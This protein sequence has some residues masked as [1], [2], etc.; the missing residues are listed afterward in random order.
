MEQRLRAEGLK[1]LKIDQYCVE[2]SLTPQGTPFTL[3]L[4]SIYSAQ[5]PYSICKCDLS[6][7]A[8]RALAANVISH[9][10]IYKV[11]VL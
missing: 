9:V 1:E 2:R 8:Q 6:S 11:Q 3:T 7:R 5:C 4:I 10:F